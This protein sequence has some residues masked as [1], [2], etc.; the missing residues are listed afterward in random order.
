MNAIKFLL[1]EKGVPRK[2]PVAA[3]LNQLPELGKPR[4]ET[5]LS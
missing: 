2:L 3:E 4:L 1:R 5:R